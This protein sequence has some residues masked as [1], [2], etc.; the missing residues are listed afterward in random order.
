MANRID[1]KL[2][3]A[4]NNVLVPGAMRSLIQMN[5]VRGAEVTDGK[6]RIEIASTAIPDQRRSWLKAKAAAMV[7]EVSGVAEVTV[8][9]VE[10]KPHVCCKYIKS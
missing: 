10:A 4:L 9:L 7:R 5:L 1:P 3:A 8:G 2:E 6:A